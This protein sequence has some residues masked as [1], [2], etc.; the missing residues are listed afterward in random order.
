[1]NPLPLDFLSPKQPSD[2]A[3]QPLL[4][5]VEDMLIFCGRTEHTR[6]GSEQAARP[7]EALGLLSLMQTAPFDPNGRVRW[8]ETWRHD[9]RTISLAEGVLRAALH[10]HPKSTQ[11]EWP[12]TLEGMA[13][14][15]PEPLLLDPKQGITA[16]LVVATLLAAGADPWADVSP[17]DPLGRVLP[18]ALMNHMGGLAERIWQCPTGRPSLETLA[19]TMPWGDNKKAVT[20]WLT[21]CTEQSEGA[22]TAAWLLAKGLVPDAQN[23]PL[24]LASSP[25]VVK[26]YRAH[27]IDLDAKA[28]NKVIGAWQGRLNRQTLDQKTFV[29]MKEELTARENQVAATTPLDDAIVAEIVQEYGAV[30]WGKSD[31]V[32]WSLSYRG[33]IKTQEI[34]RSMHRV[35]VPL[36]A[37]QGQWNLF[38][39]W[40]FRRLRTKNNPQWTL[41]EFFGNDRN[42]YPKGCLADAIG[43]DWRPGISINGL[44]AFSLSNIHPGHGKESKEFEKVLKALGIHDYVDWLKEQ[45]DAMVTFSKAFSKGDRAKEQW[46]EAWMPVFSKTPEM[47]NVWAD[48]FFNLR[49]DIAPIDALDDQSSSS[50]A[51][52]IRLKEGTLQLRGNA[53]SCWWVQMNHWDGETIRYPS[54]ESLPETERGTAELIDTALILGSDQ[55]GWWEAVE[56]RAE[57][58]LLTQA[59]VKQLKGLAEDLAKGKKEHGPVTEQA[60]QRL[61]AAIL[62]ATMP[63]PAK[64]AKKT[65]F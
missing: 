62:A 49:K 8:K 5:A 29:G 56:R 11:R 23:H 28:Q 30:P 61:R 38:T 52:R 14:M 2:T 63:P 1:M 19:S 37:T 51:Q 47:K 25:A 20:T 36:G 35:N 12:L 6:S 40:L 34:K 58:G 24:A 18:L 43:F 48:F 17:E 42:D 44:V 10:A 50:G 16:E 65:R 55:D 41:E 3:T 22:A 53:F 7:L 9:E 31:K 46:Q 15:V 39:S 64:D 32:L 33:H 45:R 26:A 59:H 13:G 21:W 60:S 4:K 27:G 54:P 57:R